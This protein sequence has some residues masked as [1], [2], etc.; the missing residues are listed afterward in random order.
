MDSRFH[1]VMADSSRRA[2]SVMYSKGASMFL[3]R[4]H[5]STNCLQTKIHDLENKKLLQNPTIHEKVNHFSHKLTVVCTGW[6]LSGSLTDVEANITCL[7]LHRYVLSRNDDHHSTQCLHMVKIYHKFSFF[8]LC[9][10]IG[11]WHC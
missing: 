7:L 5:T 3:R 11:L 6:F 10:S 2:P 9:K 8:C 1:T 4:L